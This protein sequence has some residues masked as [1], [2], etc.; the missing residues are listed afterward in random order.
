VL[1]SKFH[2]IIGNKWL[3]AAFAILVSLAFVGLFTP[4]IGSGQ[5]EKI[6]AAGT[7]YGLDI[8]KAEY[9]TAEYFEKGLVSDKV[10][11]EDE[12]AE[13]QNKTWQR[14]ATIK[15]APRMGITVTGAEV[16]NAIKTDRTFANNSG[17][18]DKRIFNQ[19]LNQIRLS[20]EMYTEYVQ[21]QL[22]IYKVK[23]QLESEVWLPPTLIEEK[24]ADLTD[25][26]TVKAGLVSNLNFTNDVKITD[27]LIA[28]YYDKN[29]E[30]FETPEKISVGYIKWSNDDMAK[31]IEVSD[32]QAGN[33]YTNYID[34]FS[35]ADTNNDLVP[36]PFKEVKEKVVATIQNKDAQNQLIDIASDFTR[37]LEP[38][39]GKTISFETIVA[40]ETKLSVAT[41]GLFS[42]ESPKV[43]EISDV[44]ENDIKMLF[45]L[46]KEDPW[47]CFSDPIV[48][49]EAVYVFVANEKI[50]PKIPELEEIKAQIT[51][52]V[53]Q[54]ELS[55]YAKTKAEEAIVTIEKEIAAGKSFD[56]VAKSLNIETFNAGTFMPYQGIT[57]N[58]PYAE[59]ISRSAVSIKQGQASDPVSIPSGALFA[60]V[61]KRTQ[62]EPIEKELIR[63]Q[64]L[65][66]LTRYRADI[67]YPQWCNNILASKE[68]KFSDFLNK[69]KQ[70]EA[71]EKEME[72]EETGI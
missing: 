47:R 67:T 39:S 40:A 71:V 61:E 62:G 50:A 6:V 13:L 12:Y 38:A 59:A 57:N 54:D 21:Q 5:T 56:K 33:Y 28:E 45:S 22:I 37:K 2:K 30:L 26:V 10:Y 9:N 58:V 1:I 46:T 18:F 60:F 3:W 24:L 66:S 42:A 44:K 65:S 19:I 15:T 14:L 64:L 34:D 8:S 31:T 70:E 35:V 43:D 29:K 68:A 51:F 36:M 32:V 17:Q 55:K 11:E 49:D 20:P 41:T 48:T 7:L 27:E 25:L 16:L 52:Y 69:P 72:E 63:P 4:G 53:K 23:K